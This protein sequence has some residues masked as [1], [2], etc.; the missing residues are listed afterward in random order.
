MMNRSFLVVLMTLVTAS[1]LGGCSAGFDELKARMDAIRKQPRGR[2]E[3]PPE[4]T[5][6]PSFTY[7]AHQLRS[8]F[9]PPE[10][11]LMIKIRQGD[12]PVVPDFSRPQEYLEKYNLE[13]LRMRG[14]LQRPGSVLYGLIEDAEGGVQ[15]VKIGNYAGK[16][17]G[18]IIEITQSQI[19]LIEIV[20]DGRDG[21]V[22][23]P[24]SIVMADK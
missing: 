22:E 18:R 3:P 11:E 23:R 13:S 15:R 9:T 8:P 17:H 14:T 12:K 6:L 4:F 1:G 7:A 19:N 24:R 10:T 20:P 16:N 2:V 21:W 5:P